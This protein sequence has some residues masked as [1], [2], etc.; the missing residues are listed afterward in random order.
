MEVIYGPGFFPLE[1]A[2]S[3]LGAGVVGALVE[4][5]QISFADWRD[6]PAPKTLPTTARTLGSLMADLVFDH[7][8]LSYGSALPGVAFVLSEGRQAAFTYGNRNYVFR[9]KLAVN[10]SLLVR[11]TGTAAN[12][13]YLGQFPLLDQ[14]MKPFPPRRLN[15]VYQRDSTGLLLDS[16]H[17]TFGQVNKVPLWIW[18][19]Y[20]RPILSG[21]IRR[22]MLSTAAEEGRELVFY[23]PPGVRLA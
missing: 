12:R 17:L 7:L 20:G 18:Q 23:C 13:R 9:P 8:R 4:A 16:V 19:I 2:Q 6:S 21:V 3:D 10:S 14:D 22:G 1:D 5:V 15:L 11:D